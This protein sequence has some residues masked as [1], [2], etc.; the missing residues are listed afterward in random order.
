M[1]KSTDD[2]VRLSLDA[3]SVAGKHAEIAFWKAGVIQNYFMGGA[4]S[5]NSVY[6]INSSLS[7]IMAWQQDG[8]INAY[9]GFTIQSATSGKEF[10]VR[11]AVAG[12]NVVRVTVNSAAA[13][14]RVRF[15]EVG[16]WARFY[17]RVGIGG[18]DP[19][20]GTNL[21]VKDGS[22]DTLVHV[23]GHEASS[24]ILRMWS[25]D[26]DDTADKFRIVAQNAG[27]L[28]RFDYNDTNSAMY[29]DSLGDW[30]SPAICGNT[31]ASAGDVVR[32]GTNQ[33]A[34]DSSARKFKGDIQSMDDKWSAK[35]WG[36]QAVSY[37]QRVITKERV[38]APD[39]DRK[40]VPY[41]VKRT[42]TDTLLSTREIGFI[43]D[44]AHALGL[45]EL[46]HYD[47]QGDVLSFN[48]RRFVAALFNEVKKL[49]EQVSALTP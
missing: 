32:V 48:Y 5:D 21:D 4:Q 47:D 14:S 31:G 20:S 17:G 37:R 49:R 6:L 42:I 16:G 29:F 2:T 10:I 44:E 9:G 8:D 28:L 11:Y 19:L 36:L 38:W 18:R 13:S 23:E 15:N 12:N 24:A 30:Y 27:N 22:G 7:T 39:V 43:A 46:V 34:I 1:L 41:E 33:V 25:D 3:P 35:I 45:T 40:T 26:G